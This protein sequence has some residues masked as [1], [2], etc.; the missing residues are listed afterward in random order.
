[1]GGAGR[2]DSL[3]IHPVGSVRSQSPYD[4]VSASFGVEWQES[5][6]ERS[7]RLQLCAGARKEA[8]AWEQTEGDDEDKPTRVLDLETKKQ[9]AIESKIVDV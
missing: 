8:L 5:Q 1:M 6:L 3:A 9:T 7:V 4:G 2:E